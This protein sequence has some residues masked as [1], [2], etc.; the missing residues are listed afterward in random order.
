MVTPPSLAALTAPGRSATTTLAAVTHVAAYSILALTVGLS[1]ARPRVG[2]VRIHPA[3]A[4]VLGAVLTLACGLLDMRDL[5]RIFRF[6]SL[7]VVTIVSLMIVTL[8]AEK[9]G[10]FR[11]LAWRVARAARGDGRR[12]FAYLFALGTLTGALFTND[13]AVLIFTPMVWRLIE[14]V[15]EDD[16]ERKHQVVYYF[17]VLYVA[18]LAAPLVIGNPIN[19]IVANWFDIG[20]AEYA[21]WM[22]LPLSLIHI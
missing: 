2:R 7:P 17:A 13:A 10:I 21:A 18:N 14:Q 22:V 15:K 3:T 8:I 4:A 16:W 6:L 19:I 5:E 12:L 1:L 20:F 9:A 11:Y